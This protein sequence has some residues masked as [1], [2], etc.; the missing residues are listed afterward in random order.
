MAK[1]VRT[2]GATCAAPRIWATVSGSHGTPSRAASACPF[3]PVKVTEAIAAAAEVSE[4]RLERGARCGLGAAEVPPVRLLVD[5][6]AGRVEHDAVDAHRA[7]V[8][9]DGE[10]G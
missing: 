5:D 8:E 10:R 4:H 2:P 7:G 1:M 6:P 9:A 3:E